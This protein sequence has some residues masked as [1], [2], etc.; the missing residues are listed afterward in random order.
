MG[1]AKWCVQRDEG[2]RRAKHQVTFV[3]QLVMKACDGLAARR[4][5]EIKH[6]VAAK[7]DVKVCIDIEAAAL[8]EIET[9]EVNGVA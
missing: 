7:N 9:T 3:A 6:Y 4:S 5:V 2:F 1:K 8:C